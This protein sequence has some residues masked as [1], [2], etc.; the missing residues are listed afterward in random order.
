MIFFNICYGKV[1]TWGQS[2]LLIL[3]WAKRFME[4]SFKKNP[5]VWQALENNLSEFII[6]YNQEA[7][8]GGIEGICCQKMYNEHVYHFPTSAFFLFKLGRQKNKNLNI[9]VFSLRSFVLN[10]YKFCLNALILSQSR[11]SIT[12][13]HVKFIV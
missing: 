6:Q 12:Y 4:L 13:M 7:F 10:W 9:E 1:S 3:S 11:C 2:L 5:Y 8:G